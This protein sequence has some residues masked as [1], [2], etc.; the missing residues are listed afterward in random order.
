MVS[1]PGPQPSTSRTCKLW[2]TWF[3]MTHLWNNVELPWVLSPGPSPIMGFGSPVLKINNHGN[4]G[5]RTKRIWETNKVLRNLW[6]LSIAAR[7]I[8]FVE[9]VSTCSSRNK[10]QLTWFMHFCRWLLL[11]LLTRFSRSLK[12]GTTAT[13]V[14]TK[15]MLLYF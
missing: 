13:M 14:G 9:Q 4:H 7:Y 1:R 5:W 6:R 2:S 12:S 8:A 3:Q 15:G 10:L 11:L